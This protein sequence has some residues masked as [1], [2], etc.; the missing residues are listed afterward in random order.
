MNIEKEL[1][2][3]RLKGGRFF[4]LFLF[5]PP[6]GDY[7]VIY[8]ENNN[9]VHRFSS[10]FPISKVLNL[11]T[12]PAAPSFVATPLTEFDTLREYLE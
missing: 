1:A 2:I 10:Y 11:T 4:T 7:F 8:D 12:D 3:G 5:P 6:R 9:E